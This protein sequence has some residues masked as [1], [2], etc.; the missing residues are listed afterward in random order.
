MSVPPGPSGTQNGKKAI[1]SP[2]LLGPVFAG[3][4]ADFYTG[5]ENVRNCLGLGL[6]LTLVGQNTI[7]L[8]ENA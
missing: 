8:E 6:L 1:I 4:A 3:S 2:C 7:F 5:R